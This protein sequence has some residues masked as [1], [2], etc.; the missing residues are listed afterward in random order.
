MLSFIRLALVLVSLHSSK[1]LRQK[2]VPGA[3]Y[4]CGSLDQVFAWED[5]DLGTVDCFKWGQTVY[6]RNM[7]RGGTERDLNC[8]GLLVQEISALGKAMPIPL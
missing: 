1:T 5:V 3:G 6:P 8:E 7:E 4:G 2:L